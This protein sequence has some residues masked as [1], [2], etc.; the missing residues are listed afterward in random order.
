MSH[1][2]KNVRRVSGSDG[3]VVLDLHRGTMFRLNPLGSR[4]LDL[5]E[6]GLPLSR[7]AEL[8]SAECAIALDV[9]QTDLK[10]FVDSLELH[11]VIEPRNPKG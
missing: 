10:E 7:I 8:I 9:A 4:I 11:G 3:G 1:L 5:W 2:A 6:S